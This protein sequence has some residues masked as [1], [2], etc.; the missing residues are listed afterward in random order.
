[1]LHGTTSIRR[2]LPSLT[3][4][5]AEAARCHLFT[6][7][8]GGCSRAELA[9]SPS[10]MGIDRARHCA[11]RKCPAQTV[12]VLFANVAF[13]DARGRFPRNKTKSSNH[14]KRNDSPAVLSGVEAREVPQ[15]DSNGKAARRVLLEHETGRWVGLLLYQTSNQTI[16]NDGAPAE[17]IRRNNSGEMGRRNGLT[18]PETGYIV[19]RLVAPAEAW[20]RCQ[21]ASA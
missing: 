10:E 4:P 11:C 3:C 1:M 2:M 14:K 9:A 19:L 13:P 8:A 18:K 6:A 7:T 5:W 20:R 12:R 17:T 15:G 21:A 16:K